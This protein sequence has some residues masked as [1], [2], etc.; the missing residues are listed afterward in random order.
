[1]AAAHAELTAQLLHTETQ[2]RVTQAEL[3]RTQLLLFDM[4][5]LHLGGGADGGVGEGG[6]AD[7]AQLPAKRAALREAAAAARFR[8][9]HGTWPAG[10]SAKRMAADVLAGFWPGGALAASENPAISRGEAKGL[11]AK[12]AIAQIPVFLFGSRGKSGSPSERGTPGAAAGVGAQ[13]ARLQA[14]LEAATARA[15]RF[16]KADLSSDSESDSKGES[17]VSAG[18]AGSPGESPGA[19]R[20]GDPG[21][22]TGAMLRSARAEALAAARVAGAAKVG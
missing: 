19:G 8:F 22:S 16:G 9:D 5:R 3:A 1:M 10:A 12:L 18:S 11:P 15:A 7:A 17:G 13:L 4:T 6:G 14:E 2:L 20:P 21:E